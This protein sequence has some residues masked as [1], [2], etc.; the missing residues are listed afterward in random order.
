MA[1]RKPL[2]IL[3]ASAGELPA[4]D[5]LL[6]PAV[7]AAGARFS[8]GTYSVAH[9][10][11]A[12][13]YYL[14]LTAANAPLAASYTAARP[15]TVNLSTGLVTLGSGAA[16]ANGFTADVSTIANAGQARQ[17]F[18]STT[19]AA[20]QK[21][22]DILTEGAN[23]LFRLLNDAQAAATTWL[24]V[25]RNGITA[26]SVVLAATAIRLNGLV[27]I[28]S[29][30][31]ND[32]NLPVQISAAAN[33]GA[34][35]AANKAGA[36]GMLFGFDNT[37]SA[38]AGVIRQV[39]ADPIDVIVSN[40]LRAVRFLPSGRALVG[41]TAADDGASLLQVAG[42]MASQDINVAGS[43]GMAGAWNTFTAT[44]GSAGGALGTASATVRWKKLGR[45][46]FVSATATISANGTG[47]GTVNVSMPFAAAGNV[48]LAGREFTNT[49]KMIVGVMTPGGTTLFITNYDGTYPG[50]AAGTT[51]LVISGTYEASA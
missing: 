49:S 15:F 50:A 24:Q 8:N 20:D 31:I 36:Y 23:W 11:D 43:G 14:L 27:S 51:T 28:N 10:M 40:T 13:S 41:A 37:T 25:V 4:G 6:L 33:V 48:G 19:G 32:V 34:F 7:N 29:A 44:I 46:V 1:S 12:A 5:D 16:V 45:T 21:V 22:S 18:N 26:T 35:F 3:Q 17:V 42:T 30:P 2:T 9:Y 39:T 47:A 38:A